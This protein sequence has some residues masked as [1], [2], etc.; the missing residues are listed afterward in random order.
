MSYTYSDSVLCVD[1]AHSEGDSMLESLCE[2]GTA[3]VMAEHKDSG[4]ADVLTMASFGQEQQ[5]RSK[6]AEVLS[7]VRLRSSALQAMTVSPDST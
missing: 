7:L 6:N 4:R 5:V 3:C 1:F 2:A